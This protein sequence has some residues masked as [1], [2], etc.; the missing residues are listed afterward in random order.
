MMGHSI[1]TTYEISLVQSK[2]AKLLVE[3]GHYHG[4]Y[5]FRP[6]IDAFFFVND[7]KKWINMV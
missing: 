6:N 3:F 2:D 5:W 4:E 7:R 1:V